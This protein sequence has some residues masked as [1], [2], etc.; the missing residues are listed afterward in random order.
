M[1]DKAIFYQ[2]PWVIFKLEHGF[3][4][5][6][7]SNVQAMVTMPDIT[8][9]PNTPSWIKRVINIRGQILPLIDLRLRLGMTSYTDK[10]KGLV[11]MARQREEDH[12]NWLTELE[13]SVKEKCEFK[14]ATDPHKCEFGKWY[15]RYKPVSLSEMHLLHQLDAPHRSIHAIAEKVR[16]LLTE[17]KFDEAFA[18]IKTTRDGDITTMRILFAKFITLMRELAKTEIAIVLANIN[19]KAALA[20]DT[21]E[22]VEMLAEDS[23][24][25]TPDVLQQEDN[26]IVP[27]MA[28][29]KNTDDIVYLIDSH[30]SVT[31]V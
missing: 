27:Y 16:C 3:Y 30:R 14:L 8:N 12:L 23:V 18:I 17:N 28:K 9:I 15:D 7:A 26:L 24:E 11:D 20:V 2:Y 5:I 19:Q 25:V 13:N 6:P 10:I 4:G 1:D 29:R 31:E 21:I 22:S